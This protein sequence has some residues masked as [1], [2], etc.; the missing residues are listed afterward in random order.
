MPYSNTSDTQMDELTLR[1]PSRSDQE[2]SMKIALLFRRVPTPALSHIQ[3]TV[4]CLLRRPINE[5]RPAQGEGFLGIC[6]LRRVAPW[7]S[8]PRPALPPKALTNSCNLQLSPRPGR[9]VPLKLPA[10][11]L[12]YLYIGCGLRAPARDRYIECAT[13]TI[14]FNPPPPLIPL[15]GSFGAPIVSP[16]SWIWT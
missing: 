10:T 2:S 15:L 3:P 8:S 11:L 9:V 5:N 12:A 7:A 13:Q 16:R 6:Y 1:Q 14:Q 4:G